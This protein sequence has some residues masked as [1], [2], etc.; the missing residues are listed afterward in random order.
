MLSHSAALAGSTRAR[1]GKAARTPEASRSASTAVRW[2]NGP[3]SSLGREAGVVM[4]ES[5][6]R[7]TRLALV[8]AT[9]TEPAQTRLL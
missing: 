2:E 4:A 8:P 1:E 7:E 5:V 6:S 9:D 3:A